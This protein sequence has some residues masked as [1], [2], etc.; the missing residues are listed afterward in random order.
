MDI[1]SKNNLCKIE[2]LELSKFINDKIMT[3]KPADK[4]SAEVVISNIIHNHDYATSQ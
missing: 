1:Y 2:Q 4:G 3:I